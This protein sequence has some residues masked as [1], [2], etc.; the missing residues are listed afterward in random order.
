[1]PL[2]ADFSMLPIGSADD[3]SR[4][5]AKYNYRY[6][7]VSCIRSMETVKKADKCAHCSGTNLIL[8]MEKEVKESMPWQLRLAKLLQAVRSDKPLFGT[9]KSKEELPTK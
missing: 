4:Y 3:Q 1:M 6:Y 9:M 7:C 8:L 5:L 2:F